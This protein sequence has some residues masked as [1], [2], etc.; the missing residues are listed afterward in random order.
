MAQSFGGGVQRGWGGVGVPPPPPHTH[1]SSG[2][3]LLVEPWA[4]LPPPLDPSHTHNTRH[5]A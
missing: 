1:I 5:E 4:C 3:E 2:A